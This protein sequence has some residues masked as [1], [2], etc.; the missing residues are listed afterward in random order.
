MISFHYAF[1]LATQ[2]SLQRELPP[3]YP[4]GKEK[5]TAYVLF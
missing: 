5:G 4:H 3:R 1:F 2:V